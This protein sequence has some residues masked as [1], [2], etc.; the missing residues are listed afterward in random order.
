MF[1]VGWLIRAKKMI[2]SNNHSQTF[3]CQASGNGNDSEINSHCYTKHDD[4][5]E[6]VM[7]RLSEVL[8]S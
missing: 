4:F 5:F 7:K 1:N 8:I 3:Q 6:C 2:R